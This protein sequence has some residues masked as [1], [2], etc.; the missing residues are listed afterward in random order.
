VGFL[1][2]LSQWLYRQ[3]SLYSIKHGRKFTDRQLFE[4]GT[5]AVDANTIYRVGS[6]TKLFTVL[7]FLVEAGD[8]HFNEPVT[9]FVPEL[10]QA[11]QKI[12][13]ALSPIDHVAW[14]DVTL[15]ALASHM[16]G[17]GRDCKPK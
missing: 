11:A 5:K 2:K 12:D 8:V 6:I 1:E 13:N 14:E 17:I 7:T 3:T 4:S 9:S 10:R 16:A 15:G